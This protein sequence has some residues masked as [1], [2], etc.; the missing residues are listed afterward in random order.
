[1]QTQCP[2]CGNLTLSKKKGTFRFTP[3]INIS[4]KDFIIPNATWEECSVCMEKLIPHALSLSLE[5]CARKLK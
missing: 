3:P 5:E 2:I 4:K 1:M